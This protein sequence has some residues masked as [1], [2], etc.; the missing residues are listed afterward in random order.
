MMRTIDYNA[1]EGLSQTRPINSILSI[2]HFSTPSFLFYNPIYS[3]S[4][5][6][7]SPLLSTSRVHYVNQTP[8]YLYFHPTLATSTKHHNSSTRLQSAETAYNSKDNP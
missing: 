3:P 2:S 6:Y 4:F 1:C 8:R 7:Y 5:R